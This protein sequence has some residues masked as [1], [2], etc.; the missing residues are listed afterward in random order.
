MLDGGV[1]GI[2]NTPQ[3]LDKPFGKE[4]L[5][6][7][8]ANPTRRGFISM[9]KEG[10][11]GNAAPQGGLGPPVGPWHGW[12]LIP[13]VIPGVIPEAHRGGCGTALLGSAQLVGINY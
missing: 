4:L 2:A 13:G 5:P 8:E 11:H 7:A 10:K 1:C 6:Q 3:V 9:G 12:V